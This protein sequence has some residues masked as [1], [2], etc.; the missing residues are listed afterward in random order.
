MRSEAGSSEPSPRIRRPDA[1]CD[2]AAL[3]SLG[4]RDVVLALQAEPKLSAVAEIAAEA[5]RSVG[6]DRA[7]P[8]QNVGDAAGWHANIERFAESR[9]AAS[10]RFRR[11]PG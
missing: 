11:R 9:R 8:I 7:P 3:L 1:L 10:S 5:H 6:G 2:F 4:D